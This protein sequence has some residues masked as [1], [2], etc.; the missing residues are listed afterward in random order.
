MQEN[1]PKKVFVLL[2][3]SSGHV[4][5]AA[6]I[7]SELVKQNVQ[8]T[9][10]ATE[11]YKPLIERTGA[12]YKPYTY[13]PASLVQDGDVKQQSNTVIHLLSTLIDFS[14]RIMPD[15]IADVEREQPDLILFDMLS[16]HAKYLIKVLENRFKQGLSSCKPPEMVRLSPSFASKYGVYPNKEEMKVYRKSD[17]AWFCYHLFWLMLKQVKFSWKHGLGVSVIN[18]IRYFHSECFDRLVIT[19][20]FRE[21]QPR[22][23]QFDPLKYKFVGCCVSEPIRSIKTQSPSLLQITQQFEPVNPLESVNARPATGFKLIYASLGTVFN[24]NIFVFDTILEA[25]RKLEFEL[26]SG[27]EFKL[28]MAVGDSVYKQYQDRIENEGFKVPA[29]CVIEPFVAQIEVLKR[30]SVYITHAGMNSASEAVHYAVPV[31]CIPI[32]ADQPL[33]A[34][35]LVELGL[36]KMYDPLHLNMDELA[37]GVSEV[38]SDA[39]YLERAIELSAI[40]RRSNGNVNGCEEILSFLNR[41]DKKND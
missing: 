6:C 13:C 40:S 25:V 19:T 35:R 39:R 30:A 22:V 7:V 3:A 27:D 21:F 29:N 36:G 34:K 37:G 10:Y 2:V 5:P 1:K 4:N 23:T 14:D 12:Q 28:I 11:S 17:N 20:V 32:Q 18:P 9:F 24:N 8:V 33:V 41:L 16:M 31:V 38:L 26:K 15:L